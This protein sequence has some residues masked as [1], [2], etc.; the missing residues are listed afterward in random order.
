MLR[1]KT[2]DSGFLVSFIINLALNFELAVVAAALLILHFAVNVP[3]WL[4]WIALALWI[5]PN[6][7]ITLLLFLLSGMASPTEYRENKNPYSQG[8]NKPNP[9][10]NKNPFSATSDK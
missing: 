5:L 10:E 7:V 4:F 8:A 6:L 1:Q 9:P 3:L 2:H